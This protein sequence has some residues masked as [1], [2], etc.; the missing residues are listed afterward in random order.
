MITEQTA[1]E[2]PTIDYQHGRV[3]RGRGVHAISQFGAICGSGKNTIGTR[4]DSRARITDEP[5]T[6]KR[7]L[8]ELGKRPN[9]KPRPAE[10]SEK[11]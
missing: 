3:G 8:G 6:C 7:C 11:E 10:S 1:I 5:I 4:R 2:R 9:L